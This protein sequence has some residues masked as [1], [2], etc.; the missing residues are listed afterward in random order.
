MLSLTSCKFLPQGILEAQIVVQLIPLSI[1]HIMGWRRTKVGIKPKAVSTALTD[2]EVEHF[3]G[4]CD[5]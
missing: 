1:S 2:M 4:L 5:A 3:L